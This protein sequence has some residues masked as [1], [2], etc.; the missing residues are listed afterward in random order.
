MCGVPLKNRSYDTT[1]IQRS[2]IVIAIDAR[3]RSQFTDSQTQEE[4]EVDVLDLTDD[5]VAYVSK[6][7]TPE[8]FKRLVQ[9]ALSF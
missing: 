9:K 4:K 1:F 5:V 2:S 3:S 8:R 7:A 6:F